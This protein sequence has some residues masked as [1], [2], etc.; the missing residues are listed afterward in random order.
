MPKYEATWSNGEIHIPIKFT[1]EGEDREE[2]IT[3]FSPKDLEEKL[4][5]AAFL[6]HKNFQNLLRG[7]V[8]KLPTNVSIVRRINEA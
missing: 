4:T 8:F 6:A 1:V 2:R 5:G 7:L 3:R